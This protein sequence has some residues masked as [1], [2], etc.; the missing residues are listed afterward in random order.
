M[1]DDEALKEKAQECGCGGNFPSGSV[2]R[3]SPSNTDG[4]GS[5]PGQ[6]A[7]ISHGAK[8]KTKKKKI[9]NSRYRDVKKR[10]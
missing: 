7:K 2:V 5:I 4:V 10:N 8:K 6:G 3:T 9:K 1:E